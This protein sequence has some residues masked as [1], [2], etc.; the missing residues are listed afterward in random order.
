MS[1]TQ[2][3]HFKTS[4]LSKPKPKTGGGMREGNE[5]REKAQKTMFISL[6]I[7]ANTS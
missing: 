7:Q 5:S 6:D 4:A 1:K 3:A 2:P